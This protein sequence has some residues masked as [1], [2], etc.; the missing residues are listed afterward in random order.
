MKLLF[1]LLLTLL[2][3][4][5]A[6]TKVTDCGSNIDC[7]K[8]SAEMCSKSRFLLS[9]QDNN[10]LISL[11][12]ISDDKCGVSFKIIELSEELKKSY[13]LESAG[14]KGKTMNCLVPI[15]YKDINNWQKI[16]NNNEKFD[17]YCSGQIKDLMQGPLKD[18]LINKFNNIVN[19]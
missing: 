7:F 10:I 17:E 19:E 9:H 1:L 3:L 14:L 13:P 8:N 5:S 15:K 2:I 4:V 12:G 11:R 6:C 18:I 16:I